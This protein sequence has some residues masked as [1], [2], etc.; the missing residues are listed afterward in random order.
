MKNSEKWR[1]T[2]SIIF[3]LARESQTEMNLKELQNRITTRSTMMYKFRKPSQEEAKIAI[4][5]V[6]LR[7]FTDDFGDYVEVMFK[8][9]R[10]LNVVPMCFLVQLYNE[11]VSTKGEEAGG[12]L[13][14]PFELRSFWKMQRAKELV[15]GPPGQTPRPSKLLTSLEICFRKAFHKVISSAGG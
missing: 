13:A 12:N 8:K 1:R 11:Q 2:Q 10:R 15:G 9:R 7:L 6:T 14:V 3:D 5:D 4:K